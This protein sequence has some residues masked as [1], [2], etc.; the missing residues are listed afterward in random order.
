[1]PDRL[2]AIVPS[3]FPPRA[4]KFFPC[5]GGNH[6]IAQ[7]YD[8]VSRIG[9]IDG[10]G[11]LNLDGEPR[12]EI[13]FDRPGLISRRCSGNR[14]ATGKHICKTEPPFNVGIL[15]TVRNPIA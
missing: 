1:M 11:K 3:Y 5:A 4:I 6:I 12:Y 8:W 7:R 14:V 2:T 10:S 13:Q 9:A 15:Q